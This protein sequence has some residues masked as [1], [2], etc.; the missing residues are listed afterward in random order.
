MTTTPPPTNDDLVGR[1][2]AASELRAFA[3][4]L[5]GIVGGGLVVVVIGCG[6]DWRADASFVAWAQALP[7]MAFRAPMMALAEHLSIFKTS[8]CSPAA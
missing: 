1:M 8:R 3:R 2:V 4:D 7:E 5:V 6:S